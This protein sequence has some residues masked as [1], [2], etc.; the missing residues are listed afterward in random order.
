MTQQTNSIGFSGSYDPADITFLLQDV[1]LEATS[2]ADKEK[3]IQAGTRHYSEM[4]SEE[5]A[6]S[7]AYKDIFAKA[8]DAGARRLGQDVARLA[9]AL[10]R[11]I[12]GPI[13]LAS[14][15]RAGAPAGVLLNRALKALGRDV[16]HY[17]ISI[18]RDKGLDDV[19]MQHILKTRPIEGLVFVDGWTGKGAI[20]SQLEESF[21]AYS[22][23]APRLVVV[24]DP[25]GR[26]W[27]AASGDDWLIPSGILGSTVSGLISRTILNDEIK[28]SG[29]FHGCK[30]WPHLA[31]HDIT[32][33]FVDEVW[34]YAQ[35]TLT[36]TVVEDFADWSQ[37][38][39]DY[40]W[41]K[42]QKAVQ[43]IADLYGV[44]NLNRIK[45]G[46]A[47]A[48]RAI[49]RRMPQVVYISSLEDPDLQAMVHLLK[50]KNIPFEVAPEQIAPYRAITLIEKVS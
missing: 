29:G 27:L 32:C 38:D 11:A 39:R 21:K 26:A 43:F 20:S 4:I 44:T 36:S 50:E 25:C 22:D 13:T 48:T 15:V 35:Q 49:L 12:D 42:S 40:H 30:T 3:A 47:E 7:A 28:A 41:E 6:P 31:D 17:G 19:A 37:S 18:I 46:I 1:A 16:V 45:P 5:K 33:S 2:I 8:M 10:D 23:Q 24:A 9:L 34:E 14:L